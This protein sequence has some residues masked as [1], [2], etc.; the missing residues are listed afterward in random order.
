MAE[1]LAEDM[2]QKLQTAG[3]EALVRVQGR[4]HAQRRTAVMGGP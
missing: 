4:A 1:S 3:S 2:Q